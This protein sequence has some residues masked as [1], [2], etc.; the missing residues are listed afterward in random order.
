MS[1]N[2]PE[3][4]RALRIAKRLFE[5]NHHVEE[6]KNIEW[7]LTVIDDETINAGAFPV[8]S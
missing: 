1:V 3:A 6:I 8:Y 2:S 5:A 4:E 7:R